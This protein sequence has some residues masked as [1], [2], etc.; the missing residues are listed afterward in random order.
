M[1]QCHGDC[2]GNNE[3]RHYNESID[4]LIFRSDLKTAEKARV[5]TEDCDNERI[6][7]IQNGKHDEYFSPKGAPEAIAKELD[8]CDDV[9]E[10]HDDGNASAIN[11]GVNQP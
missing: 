11:F 5:K 2:S 3:K 8:I 9:V 1:S 10:H 7:Y 4:R 6:L